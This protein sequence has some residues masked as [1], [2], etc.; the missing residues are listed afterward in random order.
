MTKIKKRFCGEWYQCF[1]SLKYTC[2][3]GLWG[4]DPK[5]KNSLL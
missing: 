4:G 1:P 3:G 2:G 5:T